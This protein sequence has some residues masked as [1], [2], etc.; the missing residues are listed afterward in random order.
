MGL[1]GFLNN[2]IAPE[3][4]ENEEIKGIEVSKQESEAL[5]PYE[6]SETGINANT[7]IALFDPQS[8]SQPFGLTERR[9][10][11]PHRYRLHI[12]ESGIEGAV[13]PYSLPGSRSA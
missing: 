12:F 7:N 9:V 5:S 1:G 10:S 3:E 13:P 2:I 6:K 11:F 8:F 4:D